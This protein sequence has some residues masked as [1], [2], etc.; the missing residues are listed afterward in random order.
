MKFSKVL[1][2][3][4]M[5]SLLAGVAMA[6]NLIS[7]FP[8]QG[9]YWNPVGNVPTYVYSDCFFA[10][11]G[12]NN[13]AATL[14]TWLSPNGSPNAVV[15]FQLWGD[16]G[17]PDCSNV[18]ASTDEFSTGAAGLNL[19]TLP[20]TSGGGP[21]TDGA[22]YWFVITGWGLGNPNNQSYTVGGHT[23]NSAYQDNCTFWYSNQDG[24][25]QFDG[26]NLTPEMAFEVLLTGGN[27]ATETM[28]FGSLK[29]LYR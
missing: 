11:G 5:V 22:K 8:D 6:D 15:K 28:N 27:T 4:A 13:V 21:L 18:V 10:P 29:A 1:F 3:F 16:A 2:V 12:G 25:C 23:Q 19:H 17:G 7:K 24:G 20:V 14:G 9:P 26:M